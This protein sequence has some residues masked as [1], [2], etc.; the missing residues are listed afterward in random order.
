MNI[1]N[2][3]TVFYTLD[4]NFVIP[5]TVSLTSLLENNKDLEVEVHVVHNVEDKV[6]VRKVFTF[7]CDSYNVFIHFHFVSF[8]RFR[9]LP[10]TK[11]I[12]EST[13]ARL[14][15]TEFIPVEVNQ[16]IYIDCDTVVTGSLK[17]WV[18][19]DFQK[20][21][22]EVYL[23]G[24]EDRNGD[25]EAARLRELGVDTSF[26]FNAGVLIINLKKWREEKVSQSLVETAKEFKDSLRWA[27][28]DVLN[29]FFAGKCGK[30]DKKFNYMDKVRS[31]AIPIIIHFT[32]ASKPW[33]YIDNGPFKVFY[34]K[35]LK[36]TPFRKEG[37]EGISIKRVYRKY[38]NLFKKRI[39]VDSLKSFS[40]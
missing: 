38:L 17:E 11:L 12:T 26:Y 6:L 10:I 16:G 32:G 4:L 22:K 40:K 23:F 9:H 1:N 34:K 15:L 30:I 13:Y 7:F 25:E 5:F 18:N 27:D 37:M 8:D 33:H 29:I 21:E 2:K 3:I 31:S 19:V 36:L 35:Y 28:Q 14:C 39:G 20:G 24:V